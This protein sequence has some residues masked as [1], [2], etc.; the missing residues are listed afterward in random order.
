[1]DIIAIITSFESEILTFLGVL[2]ATAI[3]LWYAIRSLNLGFS[4][5]QKIMI[6]SMAAL[7]SIGLIINTWRITIM[8]MRIP[9]VQSSVPIAETVYNV[10][11]PQIEVTFSTPVKFQDL[12]VNIYPSV[13]FT[14][15][16][17]GFLANN[18]FTRRIL[19]TPKTSFPTD[20]KIILYFS[21]LEGIFNIGY[22]GEQRLEFSAPVLPTVLEVN[23]PYENTEIKPDSTFVLSLSAPA[24]FVSDWQVNITP[25]HPLTTKLSDDGKRLSITPLG[26]LSQSTLY[27]IEVN[28]TPVVTRY[29]DLQIVD[30]GKAELEK[31][32]KFTTTK[33]PLVSSFN[34]QGKSVP[35]NIKIDLIFD[36]AMDKASVEKSLII[37]PDIIH[38]FVWDNDD[39]TLH[40][41]HNGLAKDTAYTLTLV[42][43]IKTQLGGT[44][45]IDSVFQ[46]K[47][48]GPVTLVNSTPDNNAANILSDNPLKF[49]FDQNIDQKLISDYVAIKPNI[50]Y[51][52][53]VTGPVLQI[54]PDKILQNN[55]NYTI[56]FLKNIPAI[57]GLAGAADQ[58]VSFTTAP[59][60]VS[61]NVPYFAQ[62][63]LFTCNISAAR[64]LLAYRNVN[65]TENDLISVIG[66]QPGRGSGNPYKGYVP[67]YGTYWDPVAKGV[68]TYRPTRLITSGNLNDLISEL[69]KGNPVMIWGQNGWSDPHDISWT[70]SG[71]TFIKAVNGMHSSVLRGFIGPSDNPTQILLNDPWRGQYAIDTSEFLR[72]W[73]FFK[74]A[75][76]VD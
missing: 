48:A 43:G 58:T 20:Q 18:L 35:P 42:N 64:M 8:M 1:M 52:L 62:Q 74:I 67:D 72:R 17:T 61:L 12:K 15:L 27:A 68:S 26:P 66:T 73:S 4:R 76:V 39:K 7:L 49:T 10:K 37:A 54:I 70:A 2:A 31:T 23:P 21:N 6:I 51:K 25:N 46:F 53:N 22:G 33:P 45:D 28:R 40:V 75:M 16:P 38:Y 44:S 34:P 60:Q 59:F 3:A 47:T 24:T 55:T 56:T 9:K 41:I 19:I 29:S 71:G 13:E 50:A 65:V 30:R 63:S 14:V 32:I 69:L 11:K 5:K 57:Y 36:H